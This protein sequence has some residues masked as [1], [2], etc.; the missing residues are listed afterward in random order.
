MDVP[1]LVVYESQGDD[2]NDT[3]NERLVQ[4]KTTTNNVF[5]VQATE[6]PN[7]FIFRAFSPDMREEYHLNGQKEQQVQPTKGLLRTETMK[8][9]SSS[10]KL[11]HVNLYV[12]N[13]A[14]QK[15]KVQVV[16]DEKIG[17][18]TLEINEGEAQNISKEIYTSPNQLQNY[19][20]QIHE[21]GT[22]KNLL[23]NGHSSFTLTPTDDAHTV[24]VIE[25]T[26]SSEDEGGKP[27]GQGKGVC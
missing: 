3:K 8:I 15:V 11:Y 26:P 22:N 27:Q 4:P 18:E 1:V 5:T 14:G 6:T 13:K 17:P 16:W 9:T 23:I 7:P 2:V 10:S 24:T 25:I 21:Y 20:F 19:E 12:L